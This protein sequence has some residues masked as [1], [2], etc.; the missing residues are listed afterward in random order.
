M[1]LFTV[2]VTG[3]TAREVYGGLTA[4]DAYLLDAVGKGAAAYQALITAGSTDARRRLLITA[5][6]YLDAHLWQGTAN[7]LDATTLEFPRDDLEDVDGDAVGNAA[8]LAIVERACFEMAAV[9]AGNANAAGDAD[10]G[11]NVK[12]L[13]A[14]KTRIEFFGPTETSD[15]TASVLP[16]AIDRLLG[17]WLRGSGGMPATI[18][19]TSTGTGGESSFDDCD[20]YERGE[21]W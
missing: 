20:D 6:R 10:Q 5:T 15:G 21:P 18:G 13:G 8:Q 16:V 7:A 11:S 4:C 1:A 14:G 19:P 3:G 17:L 12:A 2:T 9:L